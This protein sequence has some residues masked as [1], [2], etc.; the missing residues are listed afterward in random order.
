M[1]VL[2]PIVASILDRSLCMSA[3]AVRN[4]GEEYHRLGGLATRGKKIDVSSSHYKHVVAR[5]QV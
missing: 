3:L 2:Y 1:L 4:G 5:R